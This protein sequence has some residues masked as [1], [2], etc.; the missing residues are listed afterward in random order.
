VKAYLIGAAIGI[1]AVLLLYQPWVPPSYSQAP[2]VNKPPRPPA[3]QAV[4]SKSYKIGA[5][6]HLVLIDI[7]DK[8][9]PRR[10]AV[11]VNDFTR[12]THLTCNFDD[13]GGPFPPAEQE[14]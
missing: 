1:V 9:V 2:K 6:E 14:E 3:V 8:Y 12:T 11:Y 4:T 10:C 7:P 5:D 13:V